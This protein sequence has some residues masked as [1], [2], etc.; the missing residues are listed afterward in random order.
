M[1]VALLDLDLFPQRTK[2]L[3][4]PIP[5]D[6]AVVFADEERRW[7]FSNILIMKDAPLYTLDA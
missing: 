2:Q 4:Q 3:P 1:R 5:I 6:G 7:A